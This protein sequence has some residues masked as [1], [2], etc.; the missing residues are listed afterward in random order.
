MK[1]NEQLII[2]KEDYDLIVACLKGANKNSFSRNDAEELETELK[3]A[4]LVSN[5]E[6][7][8]DVVRLN[9]TVLVKDEKANKFL[10]VKLVTPDRADIKQRKISVLSPIG[11]ALIGFRKGKK[12][13][14]NV[15]SGMRTF[16]ILNV[17][18]SM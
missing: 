8:D 1:A 2:P 15:P 3:R 11:T 6:L 9:S 4:K 12:V 14:W 5:E 7:P 13:K 16:T 10:E 18:H 17:M